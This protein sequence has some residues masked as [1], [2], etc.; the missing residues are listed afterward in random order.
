MDRVG[1]LEKKY[2]LDVLSSQFKSSSGATY[3]RRL[4]EAFAEQFGTAYAISCVNGTATMHAALEAMGVGEGDEVI[5]P[6][7]TMSATTFAVLQANA[8]PIFADVDVDTFQICARA[9]ADVITPRTKAI[10][11]VSLYGLSPDIDAIKKVTKPQDIKIIED[12]AECFMGTY[13]G[14]LVGTL[15]DCAS[16]SFQSSKHLT[17][18]EGGMLITDDEELALNIRRVVS[19]GYAGVGAAKAKISK[20]DI[21]L[22]DYSRHVGMGWN[23][24]MPE[25]CCAA[26]LAQVERIDELVEQRVQSAAIFADY[27]KD[28]HTWFKPQLV[29]AGYQNSYWTWVCRNLNESLDWRTIRDE[30]VNRGGHGVYGAWKLTYLEPM[31]ENMSLLGRERYL[32]LEHKARYRPGLCPT[33][34]VIQPQLFQFKTNYWDLQHARDQAD[35]LASTL[36]DLSK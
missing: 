27:T 11:P 3:M 19:L 35:I 12:N 1:E 6:P 26:A 30:F 23:Y 18:G 21:Q 32:P 10:I 36:K 15:G 33:A 25:L 28:F 24:R 14:R 2:V 29:P 4:E 16:F 20:A 9:V 13:K 34:E 8:T 17:S 22:P 7:L 5:V 31:F